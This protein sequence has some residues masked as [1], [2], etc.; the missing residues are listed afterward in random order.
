L[1]FTLRSAYDQYIIVERGGASIHIGFLPDKHV[2]ENTSLYLYVHGIEFLHEQWHALG[3]VTHALELKPYG[4]KEFAVIDPSG[5]LLRI[6][7]RVSD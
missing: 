6:G 4:L 1:G 5:N 7:E 2:A 3:V